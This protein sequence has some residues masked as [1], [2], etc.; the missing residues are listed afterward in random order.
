MN[1]KV[2]YT[3]MV[4][5]LVTF[6]LTVG[7]C[8]PHIH[9][10]GNVVKEER[11]VSNF[12]AISASTGIQVL[13]TQDNFEKVVVEADEN[14]LKI[15]KTEISGGKLKIYLEEGVLHAKKMSVYVTVKT[16]KSVEGSAG[17]SVKSENKINADDMRV[18]ASSGSSVHMEVSCN[19]LKVDSSS[20]SSM[21]VTGTAKSIKADSSSGSTLNASDLVAESGEA[22]ASSGAGLKINVTK[23]VKAHASSGAGITISGNPSIRD[24]N[25]SSGGSVHFR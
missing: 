7:S 3:T 13:I 14:I 10:N 25:S 4:C 21:K 23:D 20:G 17:S 11:H 8:I 19:Q 9:G 24:T 16:L 6:S 22:S 15:L 2:W 1:R 12:D 5:L 18:H